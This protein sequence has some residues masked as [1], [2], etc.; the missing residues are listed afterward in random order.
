MVRIQKYISDCGYTSR[1]KAEELI[2]EG[3]VTVNGKTAQIGDKVD[4]N[5][6]S[7]KIHNKLIKPEEK[8]V[9]VMLNKPT[10]YLSSV[11]D[12]RGRKTVIDLLDGVKER[13]FPVGRLDYDTEG[14]IILTND[15]EFT[16]KITHP[17]HNIKKTYIATLD[18]IFNEEKSAKLK[19]G[20]EIEDYFAKADDI[21]ILN[22]KDSK[23]EVR[24]TISQGK[25]RQVRK[26]F[27][28]VGYTVIKLK[29]ISIGNLKLGELEKGKYK[30][31]S[32]K[33]IEQI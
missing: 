7:V 9:Y 22:S 19:N 32:K 14:L 20:V 24:I 28:K 12:D 2:K 27:D 13:V 8:K 10:G 15:G 29:R 25:N 4:E 1:R 26:M 5:T 23:S 18:G 16:Y 17:K 21:K 11:T 6:C 33:E 3:A 30:Y 31:L